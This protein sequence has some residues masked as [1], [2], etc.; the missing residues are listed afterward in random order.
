MTVRKFAAPIVSLPLL[1]L[2]TAGC[3]HTEPP[4]PAVSEPAAPA[5]AV[6]AAEATQ[7]ADAAHESEFE[8]PYFWLEDIDGERALDWVR[9]RNAEGAA[10][11][12]AHPEFADFKEQALAALNSQSRIPR[13]TQRGQYLYNFWRDEEHPRGVYRRT[14]LAELERDEPAWETVL[15]IDAMAA[16]DGVQWVF[17]GMDCL[18]KDYKRCLVELSPGGGDATVVREFDTETLEFVAGGFELPVAKSGLSWIDRDTV[19]V[20][21]DFGEGSLTDSGYPRIAKLWRRGQPLAEAELVFEGAT[22]SVGAGAVRFHDEAGDLDL[23]TEALDFWTRSYRHL[24]AGELHPLA[25]PESTIVEDVFQ[26][27]LVLSLK[28]DWTRGG[29]TL[30]RGAVLVAPPSSLYEGATADLHVLVEPS[31]NAIVEAVDVA[32]DAILVTM[33]DNVRGRLYRY[34]RTGDG[35]ARRPIPFPDNGALGVVTSDDD[36]GSFFVQFESF[37][38][39]PTLYYVEGP[40]WQPRAIKAQE[41]TFDGSRFAV[42]QHFAVSAD[43]TRVPYF[44]VGR[45]GLELDGGNPTHIFSYGGFRNSLTPSYSG[46]YEQLFGSYGKLWLERG[47]VFV[48]ANIRGGGEFGPG[49]HAAALLKNRHKA[50]E[51]FEAV[52][53]DLARRGV[54]T[55]EHLGI[56]GRSNGGLLVSAT[57]ARRPELYGAV[58]CGVPLTDMRRY[59]KLLAGAS[60][61]AEFG[62]PDDPDMWSYL[63]TYSPY[64]N[65]RPDTEYPPVFFFTS[66]RDDRVHPGHARKLA[67]RL[68]ELGQE[69]RYYENLEGGHGGSSTNE[70]LAHRLALAYA[71]LWTELGGE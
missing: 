55:P 47:G 42:E 66:T 64:H 68:L 4:A 3:A 45:D 28:E 1:L 48:L 5:E 44:Q 70:Q 34:T 15:D 11:L 63:E 30:A 35:W 8:D 2:L 43:G 40:G 59:H 61:M 62:D 16:A 71:H 38:T 54:T 49:W 21:T 57:L 33:L 19:F 9:A 26:G 23:V 46:S 7:S 53:E 18:P 69:V 6:A 29:T 60:W 50:F 41:A 65:L 51:D 12:E 20:G 27:S 52:A 31:A 56:E 25:M 37:T 67:A 32:G 24:A 36:S 10:K 39:P 13:V 58:I 22:A 17:K 14:T